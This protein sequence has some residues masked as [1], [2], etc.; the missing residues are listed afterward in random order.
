MDR[1]KLELRALR[2][3][4]RFRRTRNVRLLRLINAIDHQNQE[5]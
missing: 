4:W 3:W 1:L 5:C 2:I